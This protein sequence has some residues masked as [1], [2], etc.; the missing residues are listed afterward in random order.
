ML[1]KIIKE[2][3]FTIYLQNYKDS[4]FLYAHNYFKSNKYHFQKKKKIE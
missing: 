1:G 3:S 4:E 2:Y